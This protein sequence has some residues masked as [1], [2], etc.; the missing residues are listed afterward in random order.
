MRMLCNPNYHQDREH[1]RCSDLLFLL[2]LFKLSVFLTSHMKHNGK[3]DQA[4]LKSVFIRFL[5]LL[6][7]SPPLGWTSTKALQTFPLHPTGA[8][9]QCIF[10]TANG[11][12]FLQHKFSFVTLL[13]SVPSEFSLWSTR[14]CMTW[15]WLPVP[16]HPVFGFLR[17]VHFRHTGLLP[18]LS[19]LRTFYACL[20]FPLPEVLW[21][22]LLAE[23]PSCLHIS[24]TMKSSLITM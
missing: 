1:D 12:I 2:N 5:L 10:H 23:L 3:T 8:P 22:P 19:L 9:I 16:L 18:A 15:S 14:R 24:Y 4:C 11:K 7:L 20:F 17:S 13:H 6:S 21:L